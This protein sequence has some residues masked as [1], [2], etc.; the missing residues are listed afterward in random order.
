MRLLPLELGQLD[1]L[2]QMLL[3]PGRVSII[4]G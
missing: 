4:F 3:T 2:T 1:R